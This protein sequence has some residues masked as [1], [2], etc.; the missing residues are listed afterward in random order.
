MI[1][2]FRLIKVTA[3]FGLVATLLGGCSASGNINKAQVGAI[4]GAVGGSLAGAHL[5]PRGGEKLFAGLGSGAGSFVGQKL[6]SY[7]DE[8][9][10]EA[11]REATLAALGG[12]IGSTSSWENPDSGHSGT[13]VVL[14]ELPSA[15]RTCRAV[16]TD[17]RIDSGRLQQKQE[18]C[19][20]GSDEWELV[21]EV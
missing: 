13:V 11:M 18:W 12:S 1:L 9:D 16:D 3:A 4:L 8:R 17:V 5:A 15:E 2:R 6:G 10:R 20:G 7:L 21:K 19:L 14:S